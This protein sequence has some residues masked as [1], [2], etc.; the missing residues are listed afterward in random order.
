MK[1]AEQE[2]KYF[3]NHNES[4]SPHCFFIFVVVDETAGKF[5]VEHFSCINVL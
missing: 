4:F 3:I 5:F 1:S 2:K